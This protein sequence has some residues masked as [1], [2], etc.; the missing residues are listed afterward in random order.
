MT[1]RPRWFTLLVLL[2]ITMLGVAALPAQAATGSASHT[3]FTYA[4]T[5][6]GTATSATH[7]SRTAGATA[8]IAFNIAAGGG[9]VTISGY[10]DQLYRGI[11]NVSV[12]GGPQQS[13]NL[14]DGTSASHIAPWWTSAALAQGRHTVVVT[15]TGTKGSGSVEANVSISG[16][17]TTNGDFGP[18]PPPAP[19]KGPT[20]AFSASALTVAFDA[21]AS[22]DTDG[23]IASY[24]WDFGDSTT[25]TTKVISHTYA[26]PGTYTVKLTVTDN[27]GAKTT[28]QQ[29][30][31]VNRWTA[32]QDA[33][34]PPV[35]GSLA[36]WTLPARG[37]F[38]GGAGSG[39]D[40]S[41]AFGDWRGSPVDGQ[42]TWNDAADGG[43]WTFG[44]M[45]AACDGAVGRTTRLVDV[46]I[47]GPSNWAAA[48][49]GSLDAALQAGLQ[50]M[51][52]CRTVNGVVYP[53]LI[54]PAHELNGNWYAWS[55]SA[56]EVADYKA[57]MTRWETIA[58]T[59]FPEA[60]WEL[61][62]NGETTSDVTASSLWMP[63]V[64][65]VVGVDR[66]NQY[67]YIGTSY[68]GV[69]TTW[70]SGS[71]RGTDT[72][73][74]G[75]QVWRQYAQNRGVPI[76]MPEYANNGN[77]DGAG[78]NDGYWVDNLFPYIK[79]NA[80]K[81]AGQFLYE[82]WFNFSNQWSIFGPEADGRNSNTAASYNAQF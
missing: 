78:G 34:P 73:P 37:F 54:R 76:V 29:Q 82:G 81:G 30:V 4:G 38:S 53:T 35:D 33:T 6:S 24:A 23:T 27:G 12:D 8:T 50:R 31:V 74:I 49:A 3:A 19:N 26:A 75:I 22:A 55:V 1:A 40:G 25:G 48:A 71:T 44:I 59:A 11:A 41:T 46:A 14:Q 60:A 32:S 80:G 77:N 58:D 17:T 70:A 66:Y 63:G 45:S 42:S 20:S 13:V 57:T 52:A 51:R 61:C 21:S 56:A 69:S 72:N 9:T 16:I 43:G 36:A 7:D 2:L 15:V 62:F 18:A 79:A 10:R 65:D 67:P 39:I 28:A 64:F 47:G 68:A 5:W